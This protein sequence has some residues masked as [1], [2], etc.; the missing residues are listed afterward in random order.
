MSN[1]KE[2][3]QDMRKEGSDFFSWQESNLMSFHIF[4]LLYILNVLTYVLPL[5]K[6]PDLFHED[7]PPR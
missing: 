2:E 6:H 5:G 4:H 1:V 3:E 7:I